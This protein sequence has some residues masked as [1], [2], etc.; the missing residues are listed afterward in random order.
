M[1]TSERYRAALS[2]EPF[3]YESPVKFT[4][5]QRFSLQIL[6]HIIAGI[7]RAL[8]LTCSIQESGREL[9]TSVK[10]S[11]GRAILAI[12]HEVL[13]LG[14][15]VFRG[16]G[17]HTLT[18]YSYD[19]ELA[20]RVVKLLG[21]R[22]LRGSSKRGGR[23]ALQQLEE[24]LR[25]GIT[26]GITVDGP[27]GPRRV[28]KPGVAIL[29]GRTK[30][31]IIPVVFAAERAWRLRSWDRLAIPKPFSKIHC[32]FCDPISP[33]KDDSKGEMERVRL[34][35]EQDLNARH[36]A[37]EKEL[38]IDIGWMRPPAVS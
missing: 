37:L 2:E 14:M 22:A 11:E 35:V 15:W 33:P 19:G 32:V 20:A 36:A 10:A 29:A 3:R 13:P 27:R 5:K 8:C 16:T 28:S 25:R 18:S 34:L 24:A 7:Y 26:V 1:A 38:G 17:C 4:S 9:F 30:V 6:P 31:P 21:L 23:L 12:W